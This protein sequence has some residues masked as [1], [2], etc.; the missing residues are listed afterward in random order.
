MAA[1]AFQI[2]KS[3]LRLAEMKTLNAR[4]VTSVYPPFLSLPFLQEKRRGHNHGTTVINGI[5]QGKQRSVKKNWLDNFFRSQ[6]PGNKLNFFLNLMKSD[7]HN[8]IYRVEEMDGVFF[9]FPHS[10]PP[11]SVIFLLL[12]QLVISYSMIR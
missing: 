6:A 10:L 12:H 1:I 3:V 8:V 11:A 5:Y 9:S 7:E 2:R 4:F